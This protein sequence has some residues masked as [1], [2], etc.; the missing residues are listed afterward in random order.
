SNG[1][2]PPHERRQ[3]IAPDEGVPPPALAPFHRLEQEPRSFPHDQQEGAH[4]REGVGDELAP[5]GHDAVVA[6]QL[7]KDV[8]TG[9]VRLR[10]GSAHPC[11]GGPPATPP[12][13]SVPNDR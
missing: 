10:P 7:A 12:R 3:G 4:R 5:H 11:A 6:A 2:P 8:V 13:S 1:P 9:T